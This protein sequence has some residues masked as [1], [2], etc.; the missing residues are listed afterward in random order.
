VGQLV[1]FATVM[2]TSNCSQSSS[3]NERAQLL[4]IVSDGRVMSEGPDKVKQ[5][6]RRAKQNGIF[7]V[8]VIVDNPVNKVTTFINVSV[9]LLGLSCVV[10]FSNILAQ[11]GT[12]LGHWLGYYT[13]SIHKCCL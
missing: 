13:D 5:A 6:V 4:V 3:S 7:M 10:C 2:L 8:F 1:D 9:W 12:R 11:I